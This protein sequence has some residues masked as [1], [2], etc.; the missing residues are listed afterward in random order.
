MLCTFDSFFHPFDF[1]K[2]GWPGFWASPHRLRCGATPT[3]TEM[4]FIGP[5]CV[6]HA[7][8]LQPPSLMQS[9]SWSW[10]R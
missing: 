1:F 7:Q 8:Q 3:S 9:S 5:L 6:A 4:P 2:R 10:W